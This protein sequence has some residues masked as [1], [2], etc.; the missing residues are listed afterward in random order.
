MLKY[1]DKFK[2]NPLIFD[3]NSLAPN[4]T[5]HLYNFWH[6]RAIYFFSLKCIVY[7]SISCFRNFEFQYLKI[8]ILMNFCLPL[9]TVKSPGTIKLNISCNFGAFLTWLF[10]NCS[11]SIY[12]CYI[13]LCFNAMWKMH[14]FPRKCLF[15][16]LNTLWLIFAA[17]TGLL[18]AATYHVHL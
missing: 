18:P 13:S 3:R 5:Y 10:L 6:G 16:K 17:M 9:Y 15:F 12:N 7:F 14:P 4:H 2:S 1:H 11:T 8:T